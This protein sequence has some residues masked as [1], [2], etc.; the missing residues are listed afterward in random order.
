MSVTLTVALA[1]MVTRFLFSGAGAWA[2]TPC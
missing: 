2:T 1:G